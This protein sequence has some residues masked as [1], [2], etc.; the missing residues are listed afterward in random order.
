[1]AGGELLYEQKT[2]FV[3]LRRLVKKHWKRKPEEMKA[4]AGAVREA[5][6]KQP[7][8]AKFVGDFMFAQVEKVYTEMGG[9]PWTEK[10]AADDHG[11]KHARK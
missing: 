10:K 7:R 11:D 1:V 3:E 6:L 2:Y 5:L 9:Q 8:I 4:Q